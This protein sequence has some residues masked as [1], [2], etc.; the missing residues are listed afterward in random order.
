MIRTPK[1]LHSTKPTY[2]NYY[3][4]VSSQK[5]CPTTVCMRLHRSTLVV[6]CLPQT[7]VFKYRLHTQK[8]RSWLTSFVFTLVGSLL[9]RLLMQGYMVRAPLLK[10]LFLSITATVDVLYVVTL[11]PL[12]VHN[13]TG[14]K[15]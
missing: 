9:Q 8:K 15:I 7:C 2:Q 1:I 12:Q 13:R 6:V 14:G 4:P 11:R 3:R 10:K 5:Y